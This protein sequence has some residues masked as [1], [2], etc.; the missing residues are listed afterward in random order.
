VSKTSTR[1]R[2]GLIDATGTVR[3]LRALVAIGHSQTALATRLGVTPPTISVLIHPR[4]DRVSIQTYWS[5]AKL[6]SELWTQPVEGPE[7]ER[8]RNKAKANNWVS[9]LAWDDI[10]DPKARP[11]IRG[12]AKE[13]ADGKGYIDEIAVHLAMRGD[14][15]KLTHAERQE[16]IRRLHSRRWSDKRIG[17]ALHLDE[18]TVLR[19]RQDMKLEAFDFSEIR[20][21]D[22]A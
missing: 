22:S 1:T 11:N 10:D 14:K 19:N 21:V 5:V 8:S 13:R 2:A 9:P 6:Y 20:Q 17:R 15:V 4:H 3:R 16:A 18:R 7:G 12:V